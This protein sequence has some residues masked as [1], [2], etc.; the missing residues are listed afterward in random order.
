LSNDVYIDI[1]TDRL[2]LFPY[3][4]EHSLV[5]E[6]GYTGYEKLRRG[7][8]RAFGGQDKVPNFPKVVDAGCGTGLAAGQVSR[9][10][11]VAYPLLTA[12]DYFSCFLCFTV[13]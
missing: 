4:F 1:I 7:F 8:D 11:V 6:L 5:K 10:I 12:S 2:T 13:P 3:S 9:I